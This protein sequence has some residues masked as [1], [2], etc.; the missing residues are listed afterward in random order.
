[1]APE[2]QSTGIATQKGDV[3]AF[4]VVILELVS[5]MEALAYR[6]D[7][8]RKGYVRTSVVDTAREAVEDD[9]GGGVRKWVDKRLNDSYPIEIVEKLV[10]LALSCVENDPEKRP[11]MSK[12]VVKISQMFLE[13]ERWFERIG[14]VVDFT[15]SL[16]PR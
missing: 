16:A 1:M 5:G 2:F 8:E 12:V 10:R 13:S 6:V 4:G 11:D 14:K 7:K 9:D 3:Y 15:A